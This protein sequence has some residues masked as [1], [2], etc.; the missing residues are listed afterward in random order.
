MYIQ[1]YMYTC[2]HDHI[3]SARSFHVT[4][5]PDY[6]LYTYMYALTRTNINMH[7]YNSNTLHLHTHTKLHK[8]IYNT[9]TL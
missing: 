9:H 3:N 4:Y 7:A 2:I 8:H 5:V 1:T 6:V